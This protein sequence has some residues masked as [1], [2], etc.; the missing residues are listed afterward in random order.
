M[1]LI[2]S[3]GGSGTTALRKSFGLSG[4]DS[5]KHSRY[6]PNIPGTKNH[7]KAVY[8]YA[9]PI[10]AVL[11]LYSKRRTGAGWDKPH[12]FLQYHGMN[13]GVTVPPLLTLSQLIDGNE[14]IFQLEDHFNNWLDGE[15]RYPIMLIKYEV[16]DDR[17]S[18]VEEFVGTKSNFTWK[19]RSSNI[20]YLNDTTRDGMLQIYGDFQKKLRSMDDVIIREKSE[21]FE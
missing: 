15:A 9:D 7:I 13:I 8:V 5:F 21:L 12:T 10:H 4:H 14:D 3:Y 20:D 1:I 11:S 18:D 17:I 6:P 2:C 19:P 16:L